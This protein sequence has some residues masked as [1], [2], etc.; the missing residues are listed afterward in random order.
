MDDAT[1]AKALLSSEETGGEPPRTAHPPFRC[2]R[3]G[4][5]TALKGG[6]RLHATG[7]YGQADSAWRG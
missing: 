2:G 1:A 6:K 5:F 7:D 4:L 3:D